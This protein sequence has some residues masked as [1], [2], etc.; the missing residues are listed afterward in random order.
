LAAEYQ[1][2]RQSKVRSDSPVILL[3]PFAAAVGLLVQQPTHERRM[4]MK[5]WSVGLVVVGLLC[6]ASAFAQEEK[7]RPAP[8]GDRPPEG[9]RFEGMGMLPPRLAEELALT[10][11]QKDKI[12]KLEEEGAAF[13][14]QQHEKLLQILTPEQKE[15]L[16][17]SRAEMRERMKDRRGGEGKHTPPAERPADKK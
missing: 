6:A 1:A 2:G 17:K 10:D 9:R 14:K 13:R 7:G 11:K 8:K 12:K 3:K 15:K 16:E 5:H 4:V